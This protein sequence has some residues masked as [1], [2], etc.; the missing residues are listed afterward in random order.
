MRGARCAVHG[1]R[2]GQIL[3]IGQLRFQDSEQKIAA[4]FRNGTMRPL[5]LYALGSI[6]M[7][8][9]HVR[10]RSEEAFPQFIRRQDHP[11][12]SVSIFFDFFIF[13]LSMARVG[14]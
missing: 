8:I 7:Y 1:A 4:T 5:T 12:L 11:P 3:I 6:A 13:F 2:G 14:L 9:A 10:L